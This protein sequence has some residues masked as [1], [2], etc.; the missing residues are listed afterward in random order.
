MRNLTGALLAL[1]I[2]PICGI[3]AAIAFGGPGAQPPPMASIRDAFK[4]VDLSD[5]APLQRF[6]ARDR[7]QLAYRVYGQA[8]AENKG[9]VILVHGSSSRSNRMH[10]L[11]KGF[12]QAGYVAYALDIRGH[13]D[14]GT[15]GQIGYIGQLEDDVEDFLRAIQPSGKKS[16]V[17]FSAGGGFALRFA[18]DPRH[19]LFDNYLLLSPFLSQD[20]TTYRPASGGWVSVGTPRMVGLFILD[21]VGISAFNDLPVTV[22]AL[23]P[24]AR[25]FLTPSYSFALATNFRPHRNYAADI[26]GVTEPM[27]VLVGQNDDQFYPE[28]FAPEFSSRGR[29]V[30]VSIVPSTN[31]IELVLTP[32]AIQAAVSAIGRLNA[33]S[34]S[35]PR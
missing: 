2:V 27:E 30:P 26:T 4:S 18:A 6:P 34:R 9:A 12:A 29:T 28:R 5:L 13:G 10:P 32:A 23:G 7:A 31:H 11:A 19:D 8:N 16:L 1:A 14:S 22:F 35:L 15:K 17:G 25:A 21:G 3:A 24:E 33:R 20:A